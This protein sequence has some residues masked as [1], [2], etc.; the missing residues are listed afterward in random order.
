MTTAGTALNAKIAAAIGLY[1][2][3]H[4]RWKAV[5]DL[6]EPFRLH[7]YCDSPSW[8]NR[9]EHSAAGQG[10]VNGT[11]HPNAAGHAKYA[12]LLRSVI[13]LN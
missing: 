1:R 10:D 6:T 9:L 5:P 2:D 7:A 3:A 11:A 8:F 13:T 12:S 4:Y